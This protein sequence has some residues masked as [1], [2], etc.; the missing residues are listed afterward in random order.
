MQGRNLFPSGLEG[1]PAAPDGMLIEDDTQWAYCGFK[2][3]VRAR[4][5]VTRHWRLTIYRGTEWGEMYELT[6]DP[7]EERNLWNKQV[8]R[9]AQS[10]LLEMLAKSMMSACDQSP[11]P[12]ARA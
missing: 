9:R 7:A 1:L 6:E 5:L 3:P 12:T 8:N 4:T 2:H 10:D 11:L